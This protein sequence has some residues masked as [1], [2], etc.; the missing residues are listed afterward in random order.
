[1]LLAGGGA[2]VLITLLAVLYLQI[3][4]LQRQRQLDSLA[5]ERTEVVR[6]YQD[7]RRSVAELESP[8][9]VVSRATNELGMVPAPEVVYLEAAP[10]ATP[11]EPVDRSLGQLPPDETG[12]P[13][14]TV[15]PDETVTP[16]ATVTPDETVTPDATVAGVGG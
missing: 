5:R 9:A 13:D 4:M 14:V 16:D 6:D 3:V 10:A 11:T 15:T 2:A 8:E 7:L 1:V 12:T